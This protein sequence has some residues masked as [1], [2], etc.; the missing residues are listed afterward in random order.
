MKKEKQS[1]EDILNFKFDQPTMTTKA[2]CEK[3]SI[4]LKTFKTWQHR[5]ELGYPIIIKLS[6]SR[7]NV[8][9]PKQFAAWFVK[10]KCGHVPRTEENKILYGKQIKAMA[11]A[12][13]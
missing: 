12:R 5:N 10:N 7:R 9:Q 3:F 2:L 6:G 8:V 4:P 11:E 1:F 13:A